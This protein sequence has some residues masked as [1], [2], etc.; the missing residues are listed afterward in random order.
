M[1]GPHRVSECRHGLDEILCDIC[2]PPTLAVPARST[3]TGRVPGSSVRS[4]DLIAQSKRVAA[5]A[6]AARTGATVRSTTTGRVSGTRSRSV[7]PAAVVRSTLNLTEQRVFHITHVDN[8]PGIIAAGALLADTAGAKPVV[9][10]SSADT[11]EVRRETTVVHSGE[12]NDP[13]VADYV[14]FYATPD[15]L[16]WLGLRVGAVDPRL[17]AVARTSSPTDFVV[18]VS[19]VGTLDRDS[20]VVTDADAGDSGAT[21]SESPDDAER[22]LRRM[23]EQSIDAANS[24]DPV[25]IHDLTVRSAEVLVHGSVPFESITLIGVGNSRARD[26]VRAALDGVAHAPKVSVYPPWFAKN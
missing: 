12:G 4:A 11:R 19:T 7:A 2:T 20:I 6:K 15:S 26:A 24:E 22:R 25:L 8:L 18:L 16:A 1:K 10:I 5:E 21:F 13:V 3:R 14:P 9:D 17:S 23:I